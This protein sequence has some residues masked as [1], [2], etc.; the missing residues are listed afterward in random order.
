MKTE[1]DRLNEWAVALVKVS[2]WLNE[3][4]QRFAASLVS[5]YDRRQSLSPKQA[6]W[7]RILAKR[8][9]DRAPM[10]ALQDVSYG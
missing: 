9:M 10:V 4:D 3:R 6:E 2:P 7:V 1:A 5:Q 8:G